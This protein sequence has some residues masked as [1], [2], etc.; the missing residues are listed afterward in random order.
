MVS[1]I[2]EAVSKC[3]PKPSFEGSSSGS[4]GHP[5]CLQTAHE[6]QND[7]DIL[8]VLIIPAHGAIFLSV[9]LSVHVHVHL[10]ESLRHP[11]QASHLLY[12]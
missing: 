5:S 1:H 4:L 2:L 11:T 12:R 8:S 10:R 7:S 6:G 9:R 3:K